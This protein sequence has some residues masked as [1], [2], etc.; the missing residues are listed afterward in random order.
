MSAGAAGDTVSCVAQ[1]QFGIYLT[2]IGEQ[3]AHSDLTVNVR[4]HAL[5]PLKPV[6]NVIITNSRYKSAI[7]RE[8]RTTRG[9]RKGKKRGRFDGSSKIKNESAE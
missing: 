4:L 8:A 3:G 6:I 9:D 7:H 5:S 2:W 1:A